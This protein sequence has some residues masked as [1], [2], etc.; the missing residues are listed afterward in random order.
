MHSGRGNVLFGESIG[1]FEAL[2]WSKQVP[3]AAAASAIVNATQT[4]A[5]EQT[6]GTA[7]DPIVSVVIPAYNTAGYIARTLDSVLAQ[8]FTSYEII[9]V[10]DGSPD[11]PALEQA[12]QAYLPEI[13][14]IKQENRGPSGARNAAIRK[15]RGK[16]IAFLD[17]DDV[18]LPQHLARQVEA[19]END[20]NLGLVY[21]NALHIEGDTPVGTTF[22]STPQSLPV[23]FETLLRERSTVSTSSA[24]ASRQAIMEAGLFDE[25]LNRCEDFDLWLRMARNGVGMTFTREVQMGHREANG[26]AGNWELMKRARIRVYEKTLSSGP[27]TEEQARVIRGKIESIEGEL[28]LEFSKEWLLAGKFKDALRAAREANK[29]VP[30]WKLRAALIGLRFFPGLLQK[31][32]RAHL[33]RTQRRK[34]SKRARSLKD[35][36]FAG[37]TLDLEAMTGPRPR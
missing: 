7:G 27:V 5:R 1:R 19:L 17:S 18:W 12:L 8:T 35:L 31:F 16:Y 10:N 26:L 25:S 20:P 2:P 22:D 37:K 32:Y 34:R 9:L 11:T 15:A 3:R 29:W 14:Y 13:R 4:Q 36:G 30:H 23:T 33:R 28:H 24:V 21:A 6:N